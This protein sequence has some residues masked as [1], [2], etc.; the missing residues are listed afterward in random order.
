MPLRSNSLVYAALA[1]SL[2][3][4]FAGAETIRFATFNASLNRSNQGDLRADLETGTNAQ[5]E[6]VAE[7]IQ[8]VNPDVLLINEFDYDP[9]TT[10]LFIKNYLN[11]QQNPS[12]APVDYQYSF[13]APSNTG[14]ASGFDL[15]NSGA[16]GDFAPGDAQGFGFFEGQF[17]MTVIS[18]YEIDESAA[19]TFQNFLWKDMPGARLPED[20]LDVDGNGDTTSWYTA[21]ELDVL[22]LSSKSH[23][24][25]PI[26]IDGETVHFIVAHP[27]PPV[28]DGP[29]DRNGT[30]NADEIRFIADYVNGAGY[31]YDD[32]GN[33]GGLAPNS[34]FVIAGDM[35]SDP[36][37]GDS[38]PGAA[39]QL[40][41]DPLIDTS[42]TPSSQGG[43]TA[44]QLQAGAN[45]AH[46]GN[47][48]FDTA[49]FGFAGFTDGVPNPDAE[50]GNLRV[51]Y[52]LPS[53]TG[54]N[55]V[56]A[57]VFWQEPGEDP[58]PLAEFPTSDHRLVWVEVTVEPIPVPA[59][60]PLLVVGLAGF[61]VIRRKRV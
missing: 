27:T 5:L 12:V 26:K 46:L 36:F 13:T 22:R 58:F 43:V 44:A 28:F 30:R 11:Q 59:S 18:K 10:D 60:L 49:D 42:I 33:V 52:V 4:G 3:A 2:V 39:Q 34:R 51:D 25:V 23:W 40:V 37:D 54:L 19:R 57:G 15:D 38:L 48:A 6:A 47:P 24:D 56:D 16:A 14:V 8:R 32:D 7:I 53:N 21:D 20:P 61:A 17:G 45:E 50:P 55:L 31:I 29:E 41:D 9:G 35:N 1:F